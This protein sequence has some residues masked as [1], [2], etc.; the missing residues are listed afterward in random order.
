MDYGFAFKRLSKAAK[1]IS[2]TNNK[3][4]NTSERDYLLHLFISEFKHVW[5]FKLKLGLQKVAQEAVNT[6]WLALQHKKLLKCLLIITLI[7]VSC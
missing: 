3:C 7:S 4:K 1:Y 2:V 6:E 5:V